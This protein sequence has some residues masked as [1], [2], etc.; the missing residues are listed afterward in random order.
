MDLA[1]HLSQ[2]KIQFEEVNSLLFVINGKKFEI[3]E[4]VEGLLFDDDFHFVAKGEQ[5]ADFYA[6]RFG[7]I[8]YYTSASEKNVK[9][10]K[11][12]YYGEH[13]QGIF[14]TNNFLGVHGGFEILNG[15][16]Q[17][18]RWCSKA[19][20][21]GV[22]HLGIC[23][24]NTLAGV[25]KFQTACQKEGITPIIGATY[26]VLNKKNDLK[27]DIKCYVRDEEGWNNLLMINKE[28][29]VIN[30]RFIY[31]DDLFKF[32]KGLILVWDP[33]SIDYNNLP[34]YAM[35]GVHE[36][37]Y[38]VDT[39]VFEDEEKDSWYL[40]NLKKF[41][42]TAMMPV[43]ITDAYYLDQ[44]DSHIKDSLNQIAGVQ[45]YKS[46]NQYFKDKDDYFQELEGIIKD[47]NR[48]ALF[49]VE[50]LK[51]EQY[52]V[53]AC[54]DFSIKTGERH[55]PVYKM[56]DEEASQYETNE[57]LFWGLIEQ[58]LAK[59]DKSKDL[60]TYIARVE[61]EVK[62]IQ[63]GNVMDYF[64]MLHDITSW[65]KK[66]G[67]LVGLGRGS[68]GGS[69]ISMLLDLIHL[70]PI[71][72]ELL[73]ERFLNE[74]RVVK[75]L[76]D[77]DTDI[78]SLRRGEVKL[79]MEERFGQSQVISVGTYTAMQLKASIKDLG[80]IF[81]L[82][83]DDTNM[84]TSYVEEKDGLEEFFTTVCKKSRLRDFVKE[85]TDL[86]NSI[87]LIIGQ[88]KAKS[89][90]ACAMVIF[91]E[92][93][94]MYSW[95]PIMKQG[96]LLVSE[97]EGNEMEQAG[98]L[99]EDILGIKQL[100]KF[101]NILD[102]IKKRYNKDIDIYT[103]PQDDEEVLRYFRKGYNGDVFHFGSPGLT[104]YCTELLPDNIN[105]L[106]AGISLYRPG[107]IENNFHNEYVMCKS[108][109]HDVTL[110]TGTE[111]ILGNTYGVMVYQEQIMKLCQVLGGLTLVEAD[112]VRKAMVKKKYEELTKY[113]ERFIPYYVE[114][115]GVTLEYSQ[116]TWDQ[117][118]KASSYLFNRSHAA[119]Y[120]ITGY[121]CQWFKVHYPLEYWV[122]AFEFLSQD[123]I[124]MNK[125]PKYISEIRKT[126]AI[127]IYP[128]DIN[129]S[130][131]EITSTK[132]AIY[133]SISSIKQV[134]EVAS[135]Q[136][137]EDRNSKGAYFSFDEFL[138]RHTFTGS[139]VNK[140]VIENLI[141]SGAFDKIE[142]I[143]API[144][145]KRLI[146]YY[147][148]EKKVK[149]EE[150]K[151]I[152]KN[153]GEAVYQDWWWLLNQRR[154]SS[155][156]FFDYEEICS[157]YLKDYKYIDQE[158]FQSKD[159]GKSYYGTG[160][161]I[162]EVVERTSTK[163]GK[164]CQIKIDS[165]SEFLYVSIFPDQYKMLLDDGLQFVGSEGSLLVFSGMF[166]YDDFRRENSCKIWDNSEI[167]ILK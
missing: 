76:P 86:M 119:A 11:L 164:Y 70:D 137:I 103:I 108:G 62:V 59:L 110:I 142:N 56:T 139:K 71:E 81:N 118:D 160:G 90:H 151:D 153:A 49:T 10:N 19:K 60:N 68:A 149:I 2:N 157:T 9:L 121:I 165:N 39:A 91:P 116:H 69:L 80:R 48:L 147:R 129:E 29:N 154:L 77:I 40:K 115:F 54:K 13:Q 20:F 37:M 155:I 38:Q 82:S 162:I 42:L 99:K 85:H 94:D 114:N 31:S 134:G 135:S 117:I 66:Q 21:L 87:S 128:V 50:L 101:Q 15:S 41:T 72:F 83:F 163:K 75:T 32:T 43:P 111:D 55:L 27:Y 104:K 58:G 74:G 67:I 150:G 5:G 79:Y 96:D 159:L 167:L 123:D 158:D 25:M 146:D 65:C 107:A 113:K 140:S 136:I 61:K 63:L 84:V 120:A 156:A 3:I 24:K 132:G 26:T 145:R 47:D 18:D 130:A 33:K 105:D 144:S 23:E 106:I 34:L 6:Y 64:L 133:W 30:N 138:S 141:Y 36:N 95:A 53:D 125:V 14:N 12:K 92:E 51:N 127:K 88:P 152:I 44:E 52:I 148:T 124:K 22:K 102:L 46:Y 4:P 109:E 131:Q 166:K 28:V 161:Y 17:Y 97:W 8:W 7:G 122:T 143:E 45:E 126:G 100:D 89:V 57:D 35:G 73:F 93:K 98:F 16:G 1:S 112:D 78:P